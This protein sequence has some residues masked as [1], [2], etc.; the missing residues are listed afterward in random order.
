MTLPCLWSRVWAGTLP[1]VGTTSLQMQS[2]TSDLQPTSNLSASKQQ[3][4]SGHA[5]TWGAEDVVATKIQ[6]IPFPSK[7][8]LIWDLRLDCLYTI[9]LHRII[10]IIKHNLAQTDGSPEFFKAGALGAHT[11]TACCLRQGSACLSWLVIISLKSVGLFQSQF[12]QA[13]SAGLIQSWQQQKS[14][15]PYTHYTKLQQREERAKWI[16]HGEKIYSK[17]FSLN[18]GSDLGSAGQP[19]DLAGPLAHG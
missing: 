6:K 19:G 13:I 9:A 2:S 17:F 8:F 3:M 1:V 18:C 7:G 5:A 11:F 12:F 16:S 15:G 10:S 14:L 4:V